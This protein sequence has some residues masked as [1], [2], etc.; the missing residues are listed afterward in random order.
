[1]SLLIKSVG[2]M[3]NFIVEVVFFNFGFVDFLFCFGYFGYLE[4]GDCVGG[5]G[6]GVEM[7]GGF[8]FIFRWEE[9]FWLGVEVV[10]GR[11]VISEGF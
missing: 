6:I 1:M 8:G 11:L 10:L 2:V 7:F 9:G 4:R 3:F 5:E